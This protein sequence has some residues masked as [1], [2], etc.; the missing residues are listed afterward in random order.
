[1]ISGIIATIYDPRVLY[2]MI[3]TSTLLCYII[4]CMGIIMLRYRPGTQDDDFEEPAVNWPSGPSYINCPCIEPLFWA[5]WERVSLFLFV[6]III[7]VLLA[8]GIQNSWPWSVN[9]IFIGLIVII[10]ILLQLLRPVNIPKSFQCPFVPFTPLLGI[11]VN[12]FMLVSLADTLGRIAVWLAVGLL[13]YLFY[14]VKN[15]KLNTQTFAL[16]QPWQNADI[17]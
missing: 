4:I 8:V 17:T 6:Y 13:I 9:A 15:S 1:M 14:G 11:T 7:N 5:I 2:E 10:L 3:S 12:I 16:Q